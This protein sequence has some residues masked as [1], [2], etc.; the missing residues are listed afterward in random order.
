M[1]AA[2]GFST[3]GLFGLDDDLSA[4]AVPDRVRRLAISLV[5][6]SVANRRG[7]GSTVGG[8]V[9]FLLWAALKPPRRCG[10]F[11]DVVGLVVTPFAGR[12]Q[13]ETVA[14]MIL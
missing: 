6:D 13:G 5:F 4:R 2:N 1:A 7:T 12:R 11:I 9:D 8:L 14:H 10:R 3:N